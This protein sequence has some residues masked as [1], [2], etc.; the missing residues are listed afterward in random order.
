MIRRPVLLIR[1]SQKFE[2]MTVFIFSRVRNP[3]FDIITKLPCLGDENPGQLTVQEILGGILM[4]VSY[5]FLK[6]LHYLG[7]RGRKMY[8]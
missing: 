6:F 4:I 3:F 5:K 7:F 2:F 1:S 8:C